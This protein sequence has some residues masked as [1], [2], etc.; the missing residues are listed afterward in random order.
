MEYVYWC[1]QVAKQSTQKDEVACTINLAVALPSHDQVVHH[2][3][4][5][6][7]RHLPAYEGSNNPPY[8]PHTLTN[9]STQ[10][11]LQCAAAPHRLLVPFD[12]ANGMPKEC[13]DFKVRTTLTI[14]VSWIMAICS[15]LTLILSDKK[16]Q[17]AARSLYLMRS[18]GCYEV[19]AALTL[20]PHPMHK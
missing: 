19:H 5:M 4:T 20:F 18:H 6:E 2:G 7:L 14:A 16:T 1:R 12:V 3:T 15:K 11:I 9:P 10:A 8:T 13:F 17:E